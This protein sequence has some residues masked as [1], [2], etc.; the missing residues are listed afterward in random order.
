MLAAYVLMDVGF[1]MVSK[2]NIVT[3]RPQ[4][5]SVCR[6]RRVGRAAWR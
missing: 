2:H 6:G 4:G 1:E 5:N 3:D